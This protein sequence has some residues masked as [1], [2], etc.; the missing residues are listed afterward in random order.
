MSLARRPARRRTVISLT[1][2]I[3]VVFILLVFFMLASSFMDWRAL[4]LDTSAASRPAPSEQEPFVVQIGQ[5]ELR[6][7][8]DAVTLEALVEQART[9]EPTDV[10]VGLQPLG[11]TR[12]Q[13]VVDVLDALD[14]AGVEPL[15]LVDDPAWQPEAAS[16]A[17]P[18]DTAP[19]AVREAD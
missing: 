2:L 10:P 17:R 6:L 1:P 7:D 18:D 16:D 4:A 15:E 11:A 5:N 8:G 12:V 14:A 3:D 9:R 13:A 19:E